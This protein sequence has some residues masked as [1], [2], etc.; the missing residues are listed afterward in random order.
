MSRS[1]RAAFLLLLLA[2]T[3]AAAQSPAGTPIEVG[4]SYQID[5]KILGEQRTIDVQ[6]PDGYQADSARRYPLIVVLDGEYESQIAFAVTG[7]Y[8][9]M[10]RLPETIVV[11]VRNTNR[12]R[13]LTPAP[14]DGWMPPPDAGNAGGADRFLGFLA[15]ELLPYLERT[16]RTA[17]MRVLVGHSLGGLFAVYAM[18]ARPD[19]FTGYLALEPSLWWN[20]GR[21]T[22]AA[23]RILTAPAARRVRLMMVN[24]ERLGVDTTGWGGDRPMVRE[25][26]TRGETHQSM[27][28]AGMM[29][30]LTTM[31]AD[32]LPPEWQPGTAPIAMLA[33]SDSLAFRLGY[34][35]PTDPATFA[36]AARMSIDS[37][38]FADAEQVLDRMDRALG[39]TP[40]SRELRGQLEKERAAPAPAGFVQLD[41]P[42]RRPR[43]GEAARF[44]GRWVLEGDSSHVV[45]IRGSGDTIVVRDS[46]RMPD[47]TWN[48]GDHPV[49]QVTP[50]GTLEWGLPMFR[51]LA[52]LVVMQGRIEHD[53]LVVSKQVR[54]WVPRRPIPELARVD[55]FHRIA[56]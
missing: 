19:L 26:G 29:T 34:P 3:R 9:T 11:G 46:I 20:D 33:R 42:A 15:Q 41:F 56:G 37:R 18:T 49:I 1:V 43:L 31:F 21:H 25:L 50:A 52:A 5:S 40:R 6:L 39:P 44:L 45:L 27:A 30:G 55:R 36:L 22:A 4:R 48:V 2:A 51:G 10:S 23:R 32:F 28:L 24:A 17:P 12:M 7:F 8:A 53:T 13:D 38:R 47:R 54:G 14:L 35:V 16:Y